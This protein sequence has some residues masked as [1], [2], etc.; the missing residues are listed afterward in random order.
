MSQWL[1]MLMVG[2]LC[3]AAPGVGWTQDEPADTETTAEDEAIEEEAAT[4]E[5]VT[6]VTQRLADTYHVDAEVITD[7]REQQM[8]FG[9]INHALTL[10]NQLPGGATQANI[11]QVMQL[12][13]EEGMGWGQI[14]HEM[15][16]TLGKAKRDPIQD[17][18]PPE[19]P[20]E[21]SGGTETGGTVDATS[22]QSITRSGTNAGS[23]GKAK[24]K[25]FHGVGTGAG[26]SSTGGSH[27]HGH[28]GGSHGGGMGHGAGGGN[29]GKSH[30]TK[31]H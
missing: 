14:A 23:Q 20:A 6:K 22:T 17:P 29:A 3:L 25:A 28:M 15:D 8:G 21:T 16:T 4:P 30:G 27:H 7:L 31:S 1:W 24:G 26:V 18:T 9:E 2:A 5:G 19:P 11:D 10:A 12:R 13:K